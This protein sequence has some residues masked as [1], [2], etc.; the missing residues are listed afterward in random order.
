MGKKKFFPYQGKERKEA[1]R[2]G[3]SLGGR[4]RSG[5]SSLIPR[6]GGRR[7]LAKEHKKTNRCGGGDILFYQKEG[8]R[9]R[10]KKQ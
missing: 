3:K 5:I 6:W 8:G 9:K 1:A 10:S 4:D 7:G 2:F